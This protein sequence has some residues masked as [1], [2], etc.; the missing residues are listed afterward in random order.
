MI[1]DTYV[2]HLVKRKT[3]SYAILVKIFLGILF[4]AALFMALTTYIGI[5]VLLAV[6][7]AAYFIMLN[8]NVEFE[9]LYIDG[10]LSID[11]I[12]NQNKRKKVMECDKDSLVMMAP[13]D[14]YVLKDYEGTGVKVIDCSSGRSDAKKYAFIYQAGQQRTKV[15]IEPNDKLLQCIRNTTPRKIVL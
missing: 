6:C 11:K 15:I 2:E 13:L 8:L 14:S 1:Q 5:L 4:A 9:Y 3:P 10:Q 7:G 12:L